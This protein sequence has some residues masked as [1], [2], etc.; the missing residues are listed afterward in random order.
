M[1]EALENFMS[2]IDKDPRISLS[3]IG[4]FSVLLHAREEYG[5]IEP[6][7]I[8]R[9]KLMKAAKISSTATYF[10]II[11]QLHEYGYICYLPTFNRM[12]Q[13]RVALA[14]EP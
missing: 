12:S 8:K 7:P 3:H 2:G 5:G 13:S 10:K 14:K 9:K 1:K 6:F 4:V 11:R